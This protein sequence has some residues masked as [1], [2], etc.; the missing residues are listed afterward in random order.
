MRLREFLLSY[1]V[2]CEYLINILKRWLRWNL[3]AH[4]LPIIERLRV[5]LPQLHALAHKESCQLEFT[6]GYKQGTGHTNGETVETLWAEH[7]AV[8]PSTREQNGGA[9]KDSICD[10]FNSSNWYKNEGRGTWGVHPCPADSQPFRRQ[11][12]GSPTT[13]KVASATCS[14]A[15]PSQLDT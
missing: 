5:L 6:M 8:G 13:K 14:N 15:R 9:R 12:S 4:M 7:N 1:D 2:G 10:Y 11:I 3:P